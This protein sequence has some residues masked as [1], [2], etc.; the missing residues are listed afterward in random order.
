MTDDNNKPHIDSLTSARFFA[1][2]AVVFLHFSLYLNVNPFVYLFLSN[3]GIGVCFFFVLSGFI[4]TYTYKDWFAG[5]VKIN[6]YRRFIRARLARIYPMHV[7]AL[8]L[9]TPVTLLLVWFTAGHVRSPYLAYSLLKSRSTEIIRCVRKTGVGSGSKILDV[10]CGQGSL[11]L[12]LHQIGFASLTGVDPFIAR[13]IDYGNGIKIHKKHIQDITGEFDLVMFNHSFEHIPD[14]ENT[15]RQVSKILSPTGICMIRIPTVTSLPW[16]MYR[17]NWVQIDAPRH[18]YLHSIE[19]I[20]LLASRFNLTLL[21][22]FYDSHALQ[23][24][25]SEQYCRSIPLINDRSFLVNPKNSIFG[26]KE[27]ENFETM[28]RLLNKYKMGDQ[29]VLLFTRPDVQALTA[30]QAAEAACNA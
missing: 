9:M 24:L 11:L 6:D 28:S 10:G 13:D 8:L 23:F 7:I 27:I 4:L 2:I 20:R 22:Y 26:K 30:D 14:Q 25:G 15:L 18:V 16:R 17:E 12:R 21:N 5:G 19:S 3:G 29:V 1:A